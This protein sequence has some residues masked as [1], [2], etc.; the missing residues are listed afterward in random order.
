LKPNSGKDSVNEPRPRITSARPFE[1]ASSVA[2]RWNTR[3]G[4]S[5]LNTVTDEPSRMRFVRAAIAAST[6]SGA[7]MAKSARWCSPSPIKS[8]PSSSANV[9]SSMTSRIT[10]AC[11]SSFPPALRVT[12]PN[13]SSPNSRV[14]AICTEN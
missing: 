10:W 1:I 4:S 9:A 11:A 2:K 8:I 13:V 3:I 7:E 14:D 5:E 12:S 6:T